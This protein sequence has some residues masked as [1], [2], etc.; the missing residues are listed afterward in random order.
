[1][2]EG[3]MSCGHFVLSA[4]KGDFAVNLASAGKIL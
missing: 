1:M 2:F 4:V 3:V